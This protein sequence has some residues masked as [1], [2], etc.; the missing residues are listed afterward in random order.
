[1]ISVSLQRALICLCLWSCYCTGNQSVLSMPVSSSNLQCST[2]NKNPCELFPDL[3]SAG[4]GLCVVKAPC[5]YQ[6]VCPPDGRIARD[7]ISDTKLEPGLVVDTLVIFPPDL[8]SDTNDSATAE[9]LTAPSAQSEKETVLTT[10][11]A[12][13]ATANVTTASSNS[14]SPHVKTR[15]HKKGAMSADSMSVHEETDTVLEDSETLEQNNSSS[16]VS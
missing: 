15:L 7:C 5:E 4:G 16:T 11:S 13:V 2:A 12:T 9:A 10:T 14:S 3:C 1:M 6:C 8:F